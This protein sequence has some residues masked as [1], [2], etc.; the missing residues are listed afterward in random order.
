MLK[1]FENA[2]ALII[3]V[4]N[5][6]VQA[7][8]VQPGFRSL[9]ATVRDAQAIVNILTDPDLCGYPPNHVQVIVEEQAT[10]DKIRAALQT[11]AQSTNS[12]STVLVYFSGH[13]GRAVDDQGQWHTYLCPRD[14]NPTDLAGTAIPGI[15]FTAM[16]GQ[17]PA[18]KLLIVLD[19]CHAAGSADLKAP[20][21]HLLW[22]AGLSE[23]YY[24]AL[25][26]GSGRVIIASS[27]ETEYSFVRDQGDLSVFTHHFC[28]ALKGQA[29]VRGDGLI[30]VLDVYHHV[31][32]A[33]HADKPQQTPFLK[34]EADLNFP[35]AL[36]RG[37]T[38]T[39]DTGPS[40]VV[41]T[42]RRRWLEQRLGE[43]QGPLS[44]YNRRIKALE[45]DIARALDGERRV[46]L[47]ERLD[48]AKRERRKIQD[49]LDDIAE[50]LGMD[51]SKIETSMKKVDATSPGSPPGTKT[52]V[53][54]GTDE[55]EIEP[56]VQE[57]DVKKVDRPNDSS[58]SFFS[59]ID[60]F[61]ECLNRHLW[62]Q[63]ISLAIAGLGIIE[64][65]VGVFDWPSLCWRLRML[66]II[67]GLGG[68]VIF[69]LSLQIQNR[70]RYQNYD[71]GITLVLIVVVT[72][73]L[74]WF[75]FQRCSHNLLV[76]NSSPTPSVTIASL[77]SPAPMVTNVSPTELAATSAGIELSSRYGDYNEQQDA[78]GPLVIGTFY[79]VPLVDERDWYFFEITRTASI[80]VQ[81][82]NHIG[83]GQIVVFDESRRML[84]SDGRQQVTDRVIP[85]EGIPDALKN[86]S[87]GTYYIA[88]FSN[89]ISD[90]KYQLVVTYDE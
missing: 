64:G 24:T 62:G 2:H 8:P 76:T 25:T 73:G 22:K 17:I 47:E 56:T 85:N 78:L 86:L 5:Y 54:S 80:R 3:G 37:G 9:P 65:L 82:I 10:A 51:E 45:S 48:K 53:V 52:E 84:S 71:R 68:A 75:A 38:K 55:G 29:G 20:G 28:K 15:E 32:E 16:I 39:A 6:L 44:T 35:I 19:C 88:V 74:T 49:E 42:D 67:T 30:H 60:K 58:R 90:Q 18:Q 72:G 4:G 87:D 21:G 50:E 63:F 31:R 59:F 23:D 7:T 81:V 66:I 57:V 11:L 34:V 41:G 70:I 14:A 61:K 77:Q 13:G 26:S 89:Y 33:V 27:K 40:V 43:L 36:D 46:I 69:G 79:L 83:D 12:Q 1:L